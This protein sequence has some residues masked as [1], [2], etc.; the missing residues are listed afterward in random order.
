MSGHKA[1]D[2]KAK[3]NL[4]VRKISQNIIDSISNNYPSE[5]PDKFRHQNVEFLNR[6]GIPEQYGIFYS[7]GGALICEGILSAC[8]H[9]CPVNESFQFDTTFMFIIAVLMFL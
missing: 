7:M 8:Y 5:L 2:G 6:C 4:V 9:I 1:N 3:P